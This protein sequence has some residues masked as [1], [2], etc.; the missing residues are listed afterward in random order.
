MAVKYRLMF[1]TEEL[2]QLYAALLTYSRIVFP[3]EE[4][5]IT[6]KLLKRIGDEMYGKKNETTPTE[7]R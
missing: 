5:P 7:G 6:N 3:K 2:R 4:M 1:T